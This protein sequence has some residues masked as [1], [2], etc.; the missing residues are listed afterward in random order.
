MELLILGPP[1]DLA[2]VWRV[3]EGEPG[4]H[5]R[6]RPKEESR[7]S[8]PQPRGHGANATQLDGLGEAASKSCSN[9]L[10]MIYNS[11]DASRPAPAKTPAFYWKK[12]AQAPSLLPGGASHVWQGGRSSISANRK[13]TS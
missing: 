11:E 10:M 12:R 1:G 7:S 4:F 5:G 9:Q 3:L 13:V 8:C 2:A 6:S